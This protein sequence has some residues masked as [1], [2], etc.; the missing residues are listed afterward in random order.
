MT[1][2]MPLTR[3]QVTQLVDD[4]FR[5][6]DEHAPTE[7]LLAML[8]DDGLEMRMPEITLRS[9][10]EFRT[11][12]ETTITNRYFDETEEVQSL[13]VTVDGARADVRMVT[14]WRARR[15]NPPAPRSEQ[16]DYTSTKSWVVECSPETGSPIISRYVVE[17]FR[18]ERGV[19]SA[20]TGRGADAPPDVA[21]VSRHCCGNVP[22]GTRGASRR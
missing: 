18:S 9:H 19:C 21:L 7:Q 15:W 10:D 20:V 11:W 4:W 14:R 1:Q 8:V 2:T 22:P 5:A 16:V 13:D 3:D 17:E 6:L 12:Y